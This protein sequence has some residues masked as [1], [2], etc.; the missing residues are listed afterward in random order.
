MNIK[1]LIMLPVCGAKGHRLDT[2]SIIETRTP[3][4]NYIKRCGRCGKYVF[5]SDIGEMTL[6]EAVALDLKR[7]HDRALEYPAEA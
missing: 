5:R 6:T 7:R 3:E 2:P 4:T 1:A